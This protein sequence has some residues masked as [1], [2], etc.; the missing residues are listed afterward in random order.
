M[1]KLRKI[2]IHDNLDF[3]IVI[4]ASVIFSG[5]WYYVDMVRYLSFNAYIY[6]LGAQTG[7]LIS[8]AHTHSINIFISQITPSKP[9]IVLLLPIFYVYPSPTI[10]LL[11]QSI[12]VGFSAVPLYA[13]A[14]AYSGKITISAII[15]SAY[16]LFFPLNRLIFFDFHYMALF[17]FFFFIGYYLFIKGNKW[18]I[19]FF[20]LASTTDIALALAPSLVIF[21][22]IVGNIRRHI[23]S[24]K[25]APQYKG[26]FSLYTHLTAFF[27]SSL[28]FIFYIYMTSIETFATFGGTS[29]NIGLLATFANNVRNSLNYG[30][31]ILIL[32]FIPMIP[33]VTL[34]LKNWRKAYI[35]IPFFLMF[36]LSGYPIWKFNTQ[37]MGA[38]LTPLL[39]VLVASIF[40]EGRSKNISDKLILEK[41][42]KHRFSQSRKV[43][44]N[45]HFVIAITFLILVI[46][47]SVYYAPWGPLN[48]SNPSSYGYHYNSFANFSDETTLTNTEKIADKLFSLVPKNSTVLMQDNMPIL[49][50]RDRNYMFGP[51]LLPWLNSTSV[52]YSPGPFPRSYIPDYIAVDTQSWFTSWFYN[53]TDGNMQYWFTY[54]YD[55]HNYGLLG[56]DYP[57]ALYEH[58]YTGNPLTERN[59]NMPVNKVLNLSYPQDNKQTTYPVTFE[60]FLYPGNYTAYFNIT[61]KSVTNFTSNNQLAFAVTLYN[62]TGDEYAYALPVFNK[63]KIGV[64]ESIC[65]NFTISSPA[66]VLYY[67]NSYDFNGSVIFKG[68]DIQYIG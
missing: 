34:P 48:S 28:V 65:L 67:M 61:V 17:P 64:N 35:M 51:G 68:G 11:I 12:L 53:S 20:F 15:T 26:H 57:F 32:S 37:Y 44:E 30:T 52:S 40:A 38:F 49:A 27:V 9:F 21:S 62:N 33:L 14:K 31:P 42:P 13:I 66:Y 6:D 58:N 25:D 56:Y 24:R 50:N 60:P 8:L 63:S 47:I 46:L 54:F 7:S 36:F 41:P 1:I 3:Y 59:L 45:N 55:H 43:L 18:F 4:I 2:I 10:L 29:S 22:G 39:F 16:F 5:L 23:Q 19:L